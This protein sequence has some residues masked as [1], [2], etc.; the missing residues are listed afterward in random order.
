VLL[1]YELGRQ[2]FNPLAG[3]IGGLVIGTTPVVCAAARFANPDALLDALT[4]MTM[5]FFWRGFAHSGRWWFV[6]V[7]LS[8]GLAVL[9]K[10]PVGVVLPAVA[11]GLFLAWSR[12]LQRLLDR[13]IVW[14]VLAFTVVALPWYV[15][16]GVETKAGFLRGFWL[17]HNVDRFLHPMESHSGWP[18][19][20]LPILVVGFVPWSFFIGLTLW[21]GLPAVKGHQAAGAEESATRL[22]WCWIAVYLVFFSLA[23]TKLPN[24]ILPV[25]TPLALLTGQFLDRW[26]RGDIEPPAWLLALGLACLALLGT[27]AIVGF[28]LAGGAGLPFFGGLGAAELMH[29][30]YLPGLQR[31]AAIG[32]VPVVG[33]ALAWWCLRRQRR[34]GVIVSVAAAA[35]MFLG[36]LAAWGSVVFNLDKAPKPL[37]RDAGALCR[38]H[39]IRIGAYQLEYLPS[40][41]FYCQRNVLHQK[42]DAKVLEFLRTPLPVYLFVPAP[43]WDDLRV[44]IHSPHRV[45]ARHH[46]LYRNWD[47]LVVTN[48]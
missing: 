2:M 48:R 45:V 35:V 11:I 20:Y 47:V 36:P 19:Y 23:A 46:D 7:G 8:C 18:L 44:M 17:T 30:R 29:G 13:R 28:R 24:Y 42:D 3:L 38:N 6:P 1:A 25:Y 22:L 9:A 5:L 43:L 40:L 14:G 41:N 26:R 39:D 4:V 37:V 32:I 31:W 10:G 15:R 12:Q 34:D 16:V 21:Y 27:G 33:A